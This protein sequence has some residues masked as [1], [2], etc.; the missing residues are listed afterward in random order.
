MSV[1]RITQQPTK[2]PITWHGALLTEPC[3]RLPLAAPISVPGRTRTGQDVRD[4]VATGSKSAPR[5]RRSG[6]HDAVI[7]HTEQTPRSASTLPGRLAHSQYCRD[8]RAHREP[9]HHLMRPQCSEPLAS[10]SIVPGRLEE[11]RTGKAPGPTPRRT[12][13][14]A[15]RH[16]PQGG[17]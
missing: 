14:E 4:L 17:Y 10:N 15:C 13:A 9:P 3:V 6:V 1:K 16:H 5:S 7:P 11:D 12:L 2:V 8:C